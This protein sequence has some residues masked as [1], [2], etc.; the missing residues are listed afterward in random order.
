MPAEIIG[1]TSYQ[2]YQFSSRDD[3]VKAVAVCAGSGG[4]TI[5]LYFHGGTA[6]LAAASKS[7]NNYSFNY[8]YSDMPNIIDMLRNE[9]PVNVI[10]VPE[11]TNN[12][13]IST[14]VEPVGEGEQR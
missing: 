3:S 5:Y 6:A 9:A 2:Y 13:R 10:Y 14:S 8:R 1:V 7:G 4:K 12:S 11:G